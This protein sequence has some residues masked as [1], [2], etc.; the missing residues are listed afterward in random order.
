MRSTPMHPRV[1]AVGLLFDPGPSFPSR[2]SQE[3]LPLSAKPPIPK[4]SPGRSPSVD[5]REGGKD[6][7]EDA[8]GAS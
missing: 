3:G 7:A 2:D 8:T 6:A 4:A 5:F 1:L